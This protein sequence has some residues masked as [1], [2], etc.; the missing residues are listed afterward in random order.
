MH[1]RA[2][3]LL[4]LV[5]TVFLPA[6]SRQPSA[7]ESAANAPDI[8]GMYSFLREG[9][10]V[11]VTI[12]PENAVSGFVS[13][14]GDTESDRGVFLDQFF[15]TAG[16][17]GRNLA[18]TTAIV[19]GTRFQFTGKVSRGSAASLAQEGYWLLKGTLTE[20][21]TDAAGKT[22]ARVREVEFKS[23]PQDVNGDEND[24]APQK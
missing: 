2:L 16:F 17:D 6:Q 7:P 19:H 5:L 21:K 10:F 24:T 22:D 13:R 9:E 3:A 18:F 14:Y 8:S 11:Q 20:F 15:E 23:F 4:L 12:E 1:S